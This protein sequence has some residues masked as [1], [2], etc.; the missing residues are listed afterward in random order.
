ML[1]FAV[2]WAHE[3]LATEPIGILQPIVLVLVS[4]VG[5]GLVLAALARALPQVR[6]R[7]GDWRAGRSRVRTLAAAEWRARALMGELCPHGWQAQITLFEEN[8]T[9]PEGPA[10]AP[11]SVDW[12]EL[13]STPDLRPAVLRRVWA[14]S[15]AEALEAMVA[16]R[17]TDRTLEQ[18]EQ[19]AA[20]EGALWP[21]REGPAGSRPS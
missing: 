15:I 9:S 20:A 6:R 19:G 18:I 7:I 14:P 10:Q 5:G 12:A 17:Q 4:V 11:V 8:L 3:R 13:S 21:D 16:D 1:S 2:Q